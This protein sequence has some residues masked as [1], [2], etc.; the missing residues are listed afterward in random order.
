MYSGHEDSDG[1][2]DVAVG[3]ESNSDGGGGG[4]LHA[5]VDVWLELFVQESIIDLGSVLILPDINDG[6]IQ[7]G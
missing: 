4:W 7:N 5:E 2:K 3:E 1:D 6:S